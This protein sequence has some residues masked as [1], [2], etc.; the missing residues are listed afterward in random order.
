MDNFLSSPVHTPAETNDFYL[1][2]QHLKEKHNEEMDRWAQYT[3]D[4]EVFL[5]GNE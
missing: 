2:Y 1:K 5:K 3:H 4:V